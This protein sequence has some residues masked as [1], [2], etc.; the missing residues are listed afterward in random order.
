ME[1]IDGGEVGFLQAGFNRMVAGLQE[2]ERIREAFGTYVDTDVAE[3]TL[4]EGTALEGEEIVVTMMFIDIRGFTG[5]AERLSAPEVV[6]SLNRLFE[7]VVPLAVFGAPRQEDHA[8]QALATALEIAAAV[9]KN[10][11]TEI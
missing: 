1:V 3:H 8:D 7:R 10:F 2:R 9:D 5:F 6:A 4:R 11:E